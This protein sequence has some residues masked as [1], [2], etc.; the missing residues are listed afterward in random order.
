[1]VLLAGTIAS[2]ALLLPPEG[3]YELIPNHER[4]EWEES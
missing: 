4:D 3:G 2:C 1:M